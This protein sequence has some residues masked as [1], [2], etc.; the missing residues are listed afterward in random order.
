[1]AKESDPAR[2]ESGSTIRS[3]AVDPN[4]SHQD[5]DDDA[6]MRRF[7]DLYLLEGPPTRVAAS[8]LRYRPKQPSD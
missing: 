8:W 3:V 2:R 7:G 1:M 4:P 5:D 6:A